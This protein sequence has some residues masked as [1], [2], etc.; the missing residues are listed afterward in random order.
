MKKILIL[1][2]SYFP[3]PTANGICIHEIAK[4]LIDKGYQVH[5]ISYQK[6][7]D[8]KFELFQG[9]HSHKVKRNLLLRMRNYGEYHGASFSGRTVAKLALFFTRLKKILYLP[10]YPITAPLHVYKY[11]LEAKALCKKYDFDIVLSVYNPLVAILAGYKVKKELDDDIKFGLYFLDSLTNTRKKHFFSDEW[12]DTRAW[13]LEK[14]I[15]DKC[16]FILNLK[17]H[18]RHYSQK[19]YDEFA[20]KMAIVDIP[21]IKEVI[22]NRA[23]L[24]DHGIKQ[25]IINTWVYAGALNQSLRNPDFLCNIFSKSNF[26]HENELHFYSRGD[27]ENIIHN[28]AEQVSNNKII[29]HGY[30]ERDEVLDALL[31]AD[32]LISIGNSSSEQVPSKIFEYISTGKRIIHFYKNERDSC[33]T[34]LERYR[35]SL[36]INENEGLEFNRIKIQKFINTSL[37]TI[38]FSE[39][40]KLYMEN[41]PSYTIELLDNVI[42]N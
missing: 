21:L 3:K 11:Y 30:V 36:L 39:I 24:N 29:R 35:N 15:F 28:Y 17:C 19:K 23:K 5:V 33:I 12:Y 7:S 16:D 32:V 27:C 40:A 41:T 4:G 31:K 9:I 22:T 26:K 14:K 25:I 34:Y 37:E 38:T 2:G 1:T 20:R 8:A 18:E 13:R 6:N 10:I 42:S